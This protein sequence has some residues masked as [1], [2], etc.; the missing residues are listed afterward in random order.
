MLLATV[1]RALGAGEEP[2]RVL[3]GEPAPPVGL[4]KIV[5]RAQGATATWDARRGKVVVVEFWATWCGPCVAAIA[6]RNELADQF[7]DRPVQFI[8]VTDEKEASVQCFLQR[9]AMRAWFR[10]DTDRAM[11]RDFAVQGIP[12]TIV[13]HAKGVVVRDTYPTVLNAAALS[14]ALGRLLDCPALDATQ[15][16]GRFDVL[17]DWQDGDQRRLRQAVREQLGLEL[18]RDKQQVETLIF[19]Q[20]RDDDTSRRNSAP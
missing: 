4:E 17:L 10:L 14:L 5:Q 7:K 15:V 1:G 6:H 2:A 16:A 3:V 13:V 19:E 20:N 9:K 8:A 12:R 18:R 11:F